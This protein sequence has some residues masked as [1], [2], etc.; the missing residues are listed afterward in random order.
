MAH[1]RR[2]TWSLKASA[3]YSGGRPLESATPVRLKRRGASRCR[4]RTRAAPA[5]PSPAIAVT[6]RF[7]RREQPDRVVAGVGDDQQLAVLGR[8]DP[9]RLVE[10]RRLE[11]A[12]GEAAEP[13]PAAAAPAIRV[14]R[15]RLR[16]VDA[17]APRRSPRRS[18]RATGRRRPPPRR[19]AT[20]TAAASASPSRAAR[21]PSPRRS[22]PR[23]SPRRRGG[24]GVAR[25]RR[26]A[27]RSPALT[28]RGD[29][30]RVVELRGARVAVGARAPPPPTVSEVSP[31]SC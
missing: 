1:D 5:A 17:R 27:R 29:A 31:F 7:S 11:A 13:S 18:R 30:E 3:T 2:R 4:R 10:P 19:T 22:T 16:E 9:R 20:R 26:S 23:P 25:R 6:T 28:P 8:R 15:R 14:T 24:C 21:A 12:V